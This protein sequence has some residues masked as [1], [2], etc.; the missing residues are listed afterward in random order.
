MVQVT[1]NV[2]WALRLDGF[3]GTK[4]VTQYLQ[5]IGI[6]ELVIGFNVVAFMRTTRLNR[7]FA[8][9]PHSI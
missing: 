1:S 9:P 6:A 7:L 4:P 2:F 3:Q 5:S 8:G